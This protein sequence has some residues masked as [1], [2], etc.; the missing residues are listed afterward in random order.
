MTNVTVY[1]KPDCPPCN[2]TKKYLTRDNV[3]FTEVDITT[4]EDAY[5]LVKSL[6]YSYTPV[7]VSG[8]IHW[9]GFRPDKIASLK[10]IRDEVANSVIDK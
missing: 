3:A 6:G 4:D 10:V 7:V 1:T 2:A 9:S 5:K 8:D